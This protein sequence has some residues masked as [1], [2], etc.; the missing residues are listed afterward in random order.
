VTVETAATVTR[1]TVEMVQKV[2]QALRVV[3][4]ELAERL[5]VAML[6]AAKDLTVQHQMVV[7]LTVMHQVV[8]MQAM[9]LN[10][11]QQPVGLVERQQQPKAVAKPILAD[12]V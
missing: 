2:D 10:Q 12:R 5:Q 6:L 3:Q 7:A 8:A 11:A 9:A 1:P 4:E